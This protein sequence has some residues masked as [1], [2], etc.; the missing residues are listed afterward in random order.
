MTT[1]AK[2]ID[3]M[4]KQVLEAMAAVKDDPRR[5]LQAKEIS[6]GAG[7]VIGAMRTKIIYAIARGEEPDIPFMGKT[8]GRPLKPGAKLLTA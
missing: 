3:E 4:T 6:N 7:K 5:S 2:D 8:S 1:P